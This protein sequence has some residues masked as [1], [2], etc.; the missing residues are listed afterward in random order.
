MRLYTNFELKLIRIFFYFSIGVH[1]LC[2]FILILTGAWHTAAQ[3][4][5][6]AMDKI[7]TS[8][9]P[10]FGWIIIITG[11]L[12]VLWSVMGFTA[13]VKKSR[14]LEI[15]CVIL[16]IAMIILQVTL[17][18]ILCASH[19]LSEFLEKKNTILVVVFA[20]SIISSVIHLS[21]FLLKCSTFT[22]KQNL[23]EES[24]VTQAGLKP[25]PLIS[26]LSFSSEI[27]GQSI[28]S[29]ETDKDSIFRSY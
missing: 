16:N 29:N 6:P 27:Y 14:E 4:E 26:K 13:I 24:I 21:L 7:Y 25:S 9:N 18:F 28:Q 8:A 22:N 12:L 19:E 10:Y 3:N 17:F 2:G 23:E 15:I 11:V 20:I 5:S 1:G